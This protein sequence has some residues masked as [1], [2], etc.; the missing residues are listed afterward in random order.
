MQV[1][2][3]RK[4]SQTILYLSAF[5]IAFFLAYEANSYSEE[6]NITFSAKS[7]ESGW[8]IE[9]SSKTDPSSAFS[10][11]SSLLNALKIKIN[12]ELS[13]GI[14]YTFHETNGDWLKWS[15]DGQVQDCSS[16]KSFN[17]IKVRLYGDVSKKYNILYRIKTKD[18]D[19]STWCKNGAISG[20]VNSTSPITGLQ[21]KVESNSAIEKIKQIVNK[22]SGD[23]T[24]TPDAYT[25]MSDLVPI[26]TTVPSEITGLQKLE[27]PLKGIDVSYYNDKID[28]AK[29]KAAGINYAIIQVGYRGCTFGSLK[30]DKKFEYNIKSA[31]EN[32]IKVGVYYVTQAVNV[33]EAEEEAEY[34]LKH[35]GD[36]SIDYPIYIDIEEVKNSRQKKLNNK[37]RTDICKAFCDKIYEAGYETGIYSCQYYFE[38][39]LNT[40]E[41]SKYNIWVAA[42]EIKEKPST[43]FEYQMWQSSETGKVD[44][45]KGDVDINYVYYDYLNYTRTEPSSTP[46]G[47]TTTK[48]ASSSTPTDTTSSA[49]PT[50]TETPSPENAVG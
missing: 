38:S 28:W 21:V 45:I 37:Q 4:K 41:L 12:T 47:E 29:V 13:G 50:T 31:I 14:Q 35:I 8:V 36:Y 32:D 40:K 15:K 19:W 5:I 10:S 27:K 26:T 34:V 2:A 1:R 17:A 30:A 33:K 25:N 39:L 11:E 6:V 3:V 9:K 18:N 43:S 7:A 46:E 48:P 44:G 22:S 16:D 24:A 20:S 23:A 49:A 42:Y